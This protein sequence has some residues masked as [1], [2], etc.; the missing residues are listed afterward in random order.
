[1][2][3]DLYNF[4]SQISNQKSTLMKKLI[5][6]TFFIMIVPFIMAQSFTVQRMMVLIEKGTGTWCTWCP[7][8]A[9]GANQLLENGKFVALVSNHNGDQYANAYSN[10]RNSMYQISGYPTAVFD[11]KT[12]SIGGSSSGST[13]NMYLPIY[14]TRY[15]VPSPVIMSMVV[16]ATDNDYTATITIEKVDAITSS[17]LKLVFFVTESE[18]PQNWFSMTTVE[19]VN[20]M[21]VPDQNGTVVDF[22]SGNIQTVTLNF[23]LQSNW[24]EEHIEFIAALQNYEP[25]QSGGSYV[26]EIL[27]CIKQGA[28][29]LA[30]DFTASETYIDK[31]TEVT[32]TSDVTGG[33]QGPVPVEYEWFLPGAE[34]DYST[35]ENPTVT[36]TQCGT[37]DATLILDK[38]G[39]IDTVLKEGYMQVGPLPN[40]ISNPGDTVCWYTPITLD[41][42][43]PDAVFYLWEPGGETTPSITVLSSV[44]GMGSHT[45]TVTLT[46]AGGCENAGTHTIYFDECVGI[47]EK[48]ASFDVSVFPNPNSGEFILELNTERS[49]QLDIQVINTLNA[50]VYEKNGIAVN[51]KIQKHINL[52]LRSGIY[53]LTVRNGKEKIVQKLF[54][55]N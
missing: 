12:K 3:T 29:D 44:Y 17:N 48:T 13:Y 32:F 37:F 30:V 55:T 7:S 39:Q 9:V 40:I 15:G 27:Q 51:G 52:D 42:T 11:G 16:E 50:I 47:D 5:L 36:Y 31:N 49:T 34:P 1:M 21:M 20:R 54:I 14:N 35:E 28:I 46:S 38:G 19:H 33:Y 26:K 2:L 25:G 10:A 41:A 45:F 23:T 8:A 6:F 22:T 4:V 43:N 18:I 53:F 24:V